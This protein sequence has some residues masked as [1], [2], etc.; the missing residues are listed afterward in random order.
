MRQ[1]EIK[2][3]KR[4]GGEGRGEIQLLTFDDVIAQQLT[5]DFS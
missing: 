4:R 5:V 1:R 2:R 3:R